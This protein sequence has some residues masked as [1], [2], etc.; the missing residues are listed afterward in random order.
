MPEGVDL[1]KRFLIA[2]KGLE[3]DPDAGEDG[4]DLETTQLIETTESDEEPAEKVSQIKAPTPIN[5]FQHPESHPVVLDLA[6]LKKYGPEWM[7]WESETLIW[8]IP[9]DFPTSEVSDLNIHKVEAMKTLH[10][11]DTYWQRWEVFNWCTQPFANMY[12][13]FEVMQVPSTAQIM[14]SVDVANRVREDVQWSDEVRD[15]MIQACRFDGVHC[16]PEPIDFLE[17]G[18][19]NDLIDCGEIQKLW[20]DVRRTGEAPRVENITSE[21][22]V[23]MLDVYS[24]L[25][26][27]RV[28]LQDQL[29]LIAHA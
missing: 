2:L 21:Q 13:D 12:P 15:F 14:V 28:R 29:R 24:F 22:L 1:E 6:L 8:R 5:L 19:E 9:Q 27:S 11:N 25:Q 4:L 3:A 23:R 7:L 26:R 10:Y 17:V 16:P 18:S 20:P